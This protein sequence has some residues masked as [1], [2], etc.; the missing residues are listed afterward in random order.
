MPL[1]I[2]LYFNSIHHLYNYLSKHPEHIVLAPPFLSLTLTALDSPRAID[3]E[4]TP[5][6]LSAEEATLR[7]IKYLRLDNER[8]AKHNRKF[9]M[10]MDSAIYEASNTLNSLQQKKAVVEERIRALRARQEEA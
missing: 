7:S 4:L 10:K 6:Q 9:R 2:A 5:T 3:I 8:V 1:N